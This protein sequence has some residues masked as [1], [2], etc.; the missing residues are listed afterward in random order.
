MRITTK[1]IHLLL[2]KTNNHEKLQI[3]TSPIFI[4]FQF[5]PF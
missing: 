4:F 5:Y 3:T 2:E 1:Q